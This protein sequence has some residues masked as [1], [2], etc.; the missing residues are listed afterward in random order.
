MPSSAYPETG[1]ISES[2]LIEHIYHSIVLRNAD[3][4]RTARR[5]LTAELQSSSGDHESCE[6]SAGRI[7]CE[8]QS[9]IRAERKRALRLQR[10]KGETGAPAAC[11]SLLNFDQASRG[12]AAK[13]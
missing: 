1:Y 11:G 7:H 10:I 2:K 5:N 6:I 13:H 3:R 8:Q 12:L 9:S 4:Q